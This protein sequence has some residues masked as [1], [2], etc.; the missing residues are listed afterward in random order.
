MK[1]LD[2]ML[3]IPHSASSTTLG[4]ALARSAKK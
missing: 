4:G 2:S 3:M 1:K